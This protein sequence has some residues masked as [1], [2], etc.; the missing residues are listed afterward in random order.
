MKK[1]SS[2]THQRKPIS[3]RQQEGYAIGLL[4]VFGMLTGASFIFCSALNWLASFYKGAARSAGGSTKF[5]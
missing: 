4:M 1:K 3:I 5:F 2:R